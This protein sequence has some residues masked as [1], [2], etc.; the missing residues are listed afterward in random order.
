MP[1]Q[2]QLYPQAGDFDLFTLVKASD[3]R[4]FEELYNRH[5]PIL[6]SIACKRLDSREKAEDI[7]QNIFID[8]YRRR[9]TIDL[10]I[11]LSA[12]LRQALK[13]KIINEYR[14]AFNRNKYQ[15]SL[16]LK[17]HCK[18]DFSDPLEA[19]DLEMKIN[20]ILN[21]LPE[22]CKQA[23]LLS[24]KENLSYKDIS[25]GL[26]ITVSTVEKHISKALK[27]LRCQI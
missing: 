1:S 16:F 7:V 22:K 3:E 6:F 27:T 23:F 26:C 24:R 14:S 10:A 5:W 8:L 19:K 4:A 25:I 15:K 9:T 13:F 11:S 20:M 18:I 17:N 12:Y 21:R 2:K